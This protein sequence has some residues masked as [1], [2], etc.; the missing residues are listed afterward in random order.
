MTNLFKYVSAN[1]GKFKEATVTK[2]E[3]IN[4]IKGNVPIIYP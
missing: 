3:K 2:S 1:A 4:V